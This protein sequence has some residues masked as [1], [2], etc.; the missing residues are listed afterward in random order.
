[1]LYAHNNRRSWKDCHWLISHWSFNFYSWN[2]VSFQTISQLLNVEW[3]KSVDTYHS[4]IVNELKHQHANHSFLFLSG[5]HKHTSNDLWADFSVAA[6]DA[7][8][9]GNSTQWDAQ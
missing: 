2:F 6:A 9:A 8:A 5:I 7:D 4:D 3:Q 1:M